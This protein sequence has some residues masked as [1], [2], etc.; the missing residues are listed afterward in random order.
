M[1]QFIESQELVAL[2]AAALPAKAAELLAG[3]WRL[4]HVACTTLKDQLEITYAFDKDWKLVNYRVLLP[5]EG[6]VLPSISASYLAAF[7][8]ENELQDLFAVKVTGLVL[9]FGGKF[10][11][12]R[13]ERPF[14]PVCAPA[15]A[16]TAAP[17]AE[18][19]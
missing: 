12:K 2:D 11:R 17:A 14:N 10:Y 4:V 3:G 15:P 9:D 16:A 18:V 1:A 5:R 7:P 6:A 19:K 13:G 8:Y